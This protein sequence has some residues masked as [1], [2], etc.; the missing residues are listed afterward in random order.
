M[1]PLM[2]R[3]D[4]AGRATQLN[5]SVDYASCSTVC[6]PEH[7]KLSLAL[8]AGPARASVEA[9]EIDRARMFVP[10]D[11]RER[12][13][14]VVYRRLQGGGVHERLLVRL[15]SSCVPLRALDMFVEGAGSGLPPAPS[16]RLLGQGH[17]VLPT[18]ALPRRDPGDHGEPLRLTVVDG[19]RA[20]ELPEPGIRN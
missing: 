20:V 19:A 2:V 15:H 7:A 1:L 3:L 8:P 16:V 18:V 13:I 6:V 10:V 9:G 14:Q 17:D 12:G 11:P 4:Q 5:L